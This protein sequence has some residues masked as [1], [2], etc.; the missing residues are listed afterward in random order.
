MRCGCS[1]EAGLSC[2]VANSFSK[3][4]SLYGERGGALSVVCPDADQAERVLGQLKA[5][6]RAQLLEPAAARR[7]A[8]R[9]RAR[10]TPTCARCGKARCAEMRERIVAMRRSLHAV[11]SQRLPSA[12]STTS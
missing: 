5:T 8:G 7:P 10:A 9:A 2:F 4:M 11:L 3:N 1:T 6:I 12:I